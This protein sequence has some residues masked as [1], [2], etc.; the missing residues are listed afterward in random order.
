MG[1]S[2]SLDPSISQNIYYRFQNTSNNCFC[3]SVLQALINSKHAQNFFQ[4]LNKR[5]MHPQSDSEKI[6]IKKMRNAPLGS[7]LD[8]ISVAQKMKKKE[9]V[10]QPKKFIN[11]IK[12]ETS[13]FNSN[14]Q[15]DSH[16]FL[17][18][19]IESFDNTI[20]EMN[21]NVLNGDKLNGF[22]SLFKGKRE[23]SHHC[24]HCHTHSTVDDTFRCLYLGLENVKNRSLQ[25]MINSSFKDEELTDV[26]AWECQ[27]CHTKQNV[28]LSSSLTQAPKILVVQLQRFC[29]NKKTG[30]ISKML[31]F[32]RIQKKIV[33][34]TGDEKAVYRIKSI[35]IHI[36]KRMY[37]GH[38]VTM[39]CINGN[40]ILAND[41]SV[42]ALN[43]DDLNF[44]LG[45]RK[46]NDKSLP[47]P[48][49]LF[50]EKDE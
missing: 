20:N 9:I 15:H 37:K 2:E 47:V 45:P 48:Y 19:L 4:E 42:V 13:R 46:S 8:F 40:W 7:V 21:K 49:L 17:M 25:D 35:I 14:I 6:M 36:G 23:V 39:S 44:Y 50:Y 24:E 29:F 18:Y 26:N 16:E 31:N 33:L 22:S 3:N 32:V 10:L 5:A 43:Q 1:N 27:Q 41:E 38:Y 34:F 11:Q 30:K 28:T 12:N